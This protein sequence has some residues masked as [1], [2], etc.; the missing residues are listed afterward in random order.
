MSNSISYNQAFKDHQYLWAEYGPASDM[1]G[2]YVDQ[3]D[4]DL[5]LA[6]PTKATALKCL[7]SQIRYWFEVGPE[8]DCRRPD[9]DDPRLLEI[10]DRYAAW[11][12][13]A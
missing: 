2:G 4:L 5:L 11:E 7:E 8:G 6:K 12:I 1:T 10:M 3:D 13:P 9:R